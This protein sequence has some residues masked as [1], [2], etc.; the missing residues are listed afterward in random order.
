M[1]VKSQQGE[2]L[3]I[4][5]HDGGIA[6]GGV[7][8]LTAPEH[9]QQLAVMRRKKGEHIKPHYHNPRSSVITQTSEVLFIRRGK[10]LVEIYD[11]HNAYVSR[12]LL[13]DGD[14][15]L[16]LAGGHS[17]TMLTHVDMVEVKQGP[18]LGTDDKRFFEPTRSLVCYEDCGD[19]ST[20]YDD[21]P[22]PGA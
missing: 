12:V 19:G 4:V 16:L 21:R 13:R 5:H 6:N 8:F 11:Q 7:K 1:E 22:R 14:V 9:P 20:M 18:Y 15:I 17:L 3:A 10:V 2:L